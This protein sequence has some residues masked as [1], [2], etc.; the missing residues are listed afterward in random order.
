MFEFTAA[1]VLNTSGAFYAL[2]DLTLNPPKSVEESASKLVFWLLFGFTN[3][4]LLFRR[5][6][7]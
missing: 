1:N 6:S 4:L 2:Q 7:R 3:C 5:A